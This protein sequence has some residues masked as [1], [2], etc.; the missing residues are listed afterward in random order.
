MLEPGPRFRSWLPVGL[1]CMAALPAQAGKERKLAEF[2]KDRELHHVEAAQA[3]VE[4]GWWARKV[5]LAT[6]ATTMFLRAKEAGQGRHFMADQLVEMMRN[7]GD[8]FWKQKRKRPPRQLVLEC[9]RRIRVADKRVR[10][11]HLEVAR[12]AVAADKE[13]D[14]RVHCSAALKLGAELEV[15]KSG[16]YRIDGL[17]IPD[18]LA[19][20]LQ[21][22]TVATAAGQRVFESGAAAGGPRLEGL[23]EHRDERLIVRTDVGAEQAKAWHALGSALLPHLQERLD[24]APSRSLVLLV[25]QKRATFDDYLRSLRIESHAA[26]LA[27]YGTFQTIVCAE[28]RDEAQVQA[29]VLHELSHLYFWGTAPAAMP[30]WYAEGFAESFGGQGTF[31]FDGKALTIG[32]PMA[33]HRLEDLKK[34]PMTVAEL[35]T[36]DAEDLWRDDPAKALRFYSASWALQRFFLDPA[37]RWHEAFTE[38][39]DKCRGA[40]L[41][42]AD[43]LVGE[44]AAAPPRRLGDP[45]PARNLF[46]TMF[47]KDLPAIE[48]AFA[49]FVQG[50]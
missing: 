1:V 14:A 30:D 44:V 17:A 12:V 43:P 34:T 33:A 49:A 47:G 19:K 16:K 41:G 29:L 25:F 8:G 10:K 9:E 50:L 45:T 37:C 5:G 6:Q 13:G 20:W 31:A 46:Q 35:L 22:Q 24:G 15:D 4:I 3:Y 48:T 26:G 2:Q 39:E 23:H 11:S 38:W 36:G 40:V 7:F 32:A 27:E 42:A 28:G 18:A 21:D